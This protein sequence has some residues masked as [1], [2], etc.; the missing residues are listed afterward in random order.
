MYTQKIAIIFKSSKAFDARA[1]LSRTPA[2][3]VYWTTE[4]KRHRDE[5]YKRDY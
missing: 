3:D 5:N 4:N 2:S 1:I